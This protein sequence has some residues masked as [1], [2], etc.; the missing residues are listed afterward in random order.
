MMTVNNMAKHAMMT[1]SVGGMNAMFG[2]QKTAAQNPSASA[3]AVGAGLQAGSNPAFTTGAAV[4]SAGNDLLS[5]AQ[6]KQADF[7]QFNGASS[8]ARTASVNV[9]NS[10][11]SKETL[12]SMASRP[13]NL[14][15][16]QTALAQTNAGEEMDAA[17]RGVET[18]E[19]TFSIEVGGETHT[20]SITVD[21]NDTNESIQARMAEA[22]NEADIGVTAAVTTDEEEG[23]TALSLTS[24]ST[25]TDAAF[26]V[27]D[28]SGNLASAMGI[29]D[30]TQEAQNAVYSVNG[31]PEI[32]S[33][34][35]TAVLKLNPSQIP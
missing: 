24:D 14:D 11:A 7:S 21:E 8:N 17:Q 28:E 30:A 34:S 20:F 35:N 23:T 22:I 1:G 31:G 2:T 26:T 19:H 6:G 16:R 12:E 3:P 5:A 13:M 9:D 27:T 15:V 29:T 10:K 25:G 33:Q 32:E 18:G 4:R